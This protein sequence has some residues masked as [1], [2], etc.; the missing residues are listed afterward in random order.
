[1]CYAGVMLHMPSSYMINLFQD[2][3]YLFFL[4]P[5][6]SV[7]LQSIFDKATCNLVLV[8]LTRGAGTSAMKCACLI[9]ICNRSGSSS[10]A[11]VAM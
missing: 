5:T 10:P 1:M 8:P 9:G 7:T 4:F 3:R 6:R 11:S 2:S